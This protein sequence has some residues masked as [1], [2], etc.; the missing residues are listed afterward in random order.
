LVRLP[1]SV[2]ER[3]AITAIRKGALMSPN[4]TKRTPHLPSPMSVLGA[5]AEMV[6]SLAVMEN[7]TQLLL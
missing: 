7:L 2:V 5:K 1:Q 3:K 4:G 6:R